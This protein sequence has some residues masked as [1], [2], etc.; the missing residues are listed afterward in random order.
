MSSK[1][2][3]NPGLVTRAECAE[4]SGGIKREMLIIRNAMVGEDMQGGLVKKFTD[5]SEKLNTVVTMHNTEVAEREKREAKH[6]KLKLAVFGLFM[7]I[8]G[9]IIENIISRIP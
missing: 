6:W 1:K 5:L 9:F 3:S 4:I 8:I 7:T 2:K